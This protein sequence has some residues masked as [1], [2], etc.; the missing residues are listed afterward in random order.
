LLW[1][2]LVGL[3]TACGAAGTDTPAVTTW[4]Y[5][6]EVLGDRER[7]LSIEP[8]G[9][10]ESM[11]LDDHK[12]YGGK[13]AASQIRDLKALTSDSQFD[14]YMRQ[15]SDC[16]TVRAADAAQS[17]TWREQRGGGAHLRQGCWIRMGVDDPETVEFLDTLSDLQRQLAR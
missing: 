13:L 7:Y 10:Y 6:G 9:A 15:S 14:D 3:S 8:D 5:F 2:G 11:A 17:V 16:E 12:A 1:G 4:L